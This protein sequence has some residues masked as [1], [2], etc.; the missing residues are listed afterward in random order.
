[1]TVRA[2][3]PGGNI[4]P[5]PGPGSGPDRARPLLS[6]RTCLILIAALVIGIVAGALTYLAGNHIADAVLAGGAA[7]AAAVPALHTLID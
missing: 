1:M 4:A 5:G 7:F 6:Q 2:R 3:P